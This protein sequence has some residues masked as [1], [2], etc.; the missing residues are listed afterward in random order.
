MV[1]ASTKEPGCISLPLTTAHNDA[2]QFP[3]GGRHKAGLL[4]VPS[5]NNGLKHASSTNLLCVLDSLL[6]NFTLMTKNPEV[7]Y[8]NQDIIWSKFETIFFTISGLV[9]YAPVFRDYIFRGLEEFYQDNVFYLE[10]RAMLFPVSQ[11][12][13][14]SVLA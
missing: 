9:N 12:L 14:S 6:S 5:G 13:F 10:L 4:Q 3:L 8:A 7:T 1:E 11:S 2:Y